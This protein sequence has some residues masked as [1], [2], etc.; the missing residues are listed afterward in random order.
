MPMN[1]LMPVAG[2]TPP[3]TSTTGPTTSRKYVLL[4]TSYLQEFSPA[5][6]LLMHVGKKLSTRKC[7]CAGV[8]TA[9]G[10]TSDLFTRGS[11]HK[12]KGKR[13][14]SC[15]M[16]SCQSCVWSVQ[17]NTAYINAQFTWL[18]TQLKASTADHN[19][20]LV[21]LHVR[22]IFRPTRRDIVWPYLQHL[23]DMA[24]GVPLCI[25][26]FKSKVSVMGDETYLPCSYS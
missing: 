19:L 20:V 21:R 22:S 12:L 6:F 15:R 8:I 26:D 16:N 9:F 4:K 11:R 17:L 24:I 23:K 14:H 2:T 10:V 13:D 3:P 5:K 18:D 1:Q 7:C 25:T